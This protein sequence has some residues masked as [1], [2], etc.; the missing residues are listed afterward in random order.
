MKMIREKVECILKEVG[1]NEIKVKTIYNG[2]YKNA[3]ASLLGS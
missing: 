3:I 2:R 1:L